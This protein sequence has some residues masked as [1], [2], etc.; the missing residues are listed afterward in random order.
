MKVK[1]TYKISASA[2]FTF[3]ILSSFNVIP[4][5]SAEIQPWIVV[6]AAPMVV[7]RIMSSPSNRQLNIHFTLLFSILFLF[8]C[9]GIYKYGASAIVDGLLY[10]CG[11]VLLLYFYYFG[12]AVDYVRTLICI[13]GLLILVAFL[14]LLLPQAIGLQLD[15]VAGH[16]VKRLSFSTN[17]SESVRGLSLLFSEPSHA[18]R[19][20]WL[21]SMVFLFKLSSLTVNRKFTIAFMLLFLIVTNGSATIYVLI[22]ITLLGYA[23]YSRRDVALW[24]MRVIG[25]LG[26]LI[27]AITLSLSYDFGRVSQ[28]VSRTMALLLFGQVEAWQLQVFGGIRLISEIAAVKIFFAWPFGYGVSASKHELLPVLLEMGLSSRNSWSLWYLM[29]DNSS[30]TIKPSSYYSQLLVDAGVFSLILFYGLRKLARGS[31]F[32][33]FSPLAKGFLLASIFQL[34]FLSTTS[35]PAPWVAIGLICGTMTKDR[36]WVVAPYRSQG[37]G[38]G[39]TS[40]G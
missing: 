10:V 27:L 22:A 32:C 21:L 36:R 39:T 13:V 15:T 35:L 8:S 9:V 18:A 3:S 24:L 33:R 17:N 37:R 19:A 16:I 40:L 2:I 12:G 31:F 7:W 28:L 38:E 5:V 4:A 26:I 30:G 20:I 11:P 25:V 34:L 1:K 29:Q 6:F 23:F 14:Q